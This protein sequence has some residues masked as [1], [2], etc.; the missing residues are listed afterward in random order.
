MP[1]HCL[2]RD[3]EPRN[4]GPLSDPAKPILVK[5]VRHDAEQAVRFGWGFLA[6]LF[7]VAVVDLTIAFAGTITL[8][9]RSL[10]RPTSSAWRGYILEATD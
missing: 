7:V 10:T 5:V 6:R 1:V 3:T 4:D 2:T 8:L 9:A